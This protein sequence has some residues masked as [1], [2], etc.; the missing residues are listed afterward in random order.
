M[1]KMV[2]GAVLI[3][4]RENVGGKKSLGLSDP[5]KIVKDGSRREILVR[6]GLLAFVQWSSVAT[7]GHDGPHRQSPG[8]ASSEREWAQR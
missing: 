6:P 5:I 1:Y 7:I 4:Y 2:S 8:E 3:V